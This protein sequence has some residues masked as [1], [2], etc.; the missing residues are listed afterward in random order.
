MAE[1]IDY[2]WL[3]MKSIFNTSFF[4]HV[5][6]LRE[7]PRP[8]KCFDRCSADIKKTNVEDSSL[9]PTVAQKCMSQFDWLVMLFTAEPGWFMFY[10]KSLHLSKKH[11]NSTV[12]SSDYV[13]K[14]V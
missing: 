1:I 5:D 10:R 12:I 3:R 4:N 9:L 14:S 2:N 11:T 7:N 6:V 13:F 8:V